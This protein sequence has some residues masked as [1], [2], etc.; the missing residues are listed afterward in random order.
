MSDA[1]KYPSSTRQVTFTIWMTFPVPVDVTEEE[2]LR[3]IEEWLEACG[4]RIVAPEE[5]KG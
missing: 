3:E 4:C 1:I 2:A 5:I